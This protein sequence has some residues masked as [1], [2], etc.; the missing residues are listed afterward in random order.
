LV[1]WVGTAKTQGAKSQAPDQT[2][3]AVFDQ[4]DIEIQEE[5]NPVA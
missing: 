1:G 2:P 4:D 5:T 3:D